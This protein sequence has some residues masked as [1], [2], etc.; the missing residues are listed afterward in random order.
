MINQESADEEAK[1]KLAMKVQEF[2]EKRDEI[3]QGLM[4]NN[5]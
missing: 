5:D 1:D 2:K 4:R 3:N